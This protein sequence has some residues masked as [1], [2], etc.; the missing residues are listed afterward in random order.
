MVEPFYI[1]TSGGDHIFG[2]IT[3]YS[4]RDSEW[5]ATLIDSS[6][7]GYGIYNPWPNPLGYAID[8]GYVAVYRQFQGLYTEG[9]TAGY[10]GASQSEDGEEW[11]TE[12]TLNTRYPTGEEEPSLPT[13]SGLPEEDTPAQDMH[14]TGI[15]LLFGMSIPIQTMAAVPMAVIPSIPMIPRDR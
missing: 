9:G 3:T 6:L 11:F 14:R 15:P 2:P 4:N 1:N 13:A 7:N 5:S 12:Q 8:E 10:I